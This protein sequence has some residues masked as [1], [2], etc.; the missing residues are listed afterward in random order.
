MNKAERRERILQ[1][2]RAGEAVSVSALSE[3]MGVSEVTIRK[4]LQQMEREGC[5]R[6]SY[7]KIALPE[8]GGE[9]GAAP[10]PERRDEDAGKRRIGALAA[11]FVRDEDLIFIGPGQTCA[12]LARSLRD[13]K[14][15]S[16]ITMNVSAAIELS[17]A[18]EFKLLLAPG[19]FTRRGGAYYVT[20]PVTAQYVEG[21]FVDKLFITADGV[22]IARGFSVLDEITAQIYRALIKPGTRIYVCVSGD[23]LS[24]NARAALGALDFADAVIT[25]ARPGEEFMRKFAENHIEVYYPTDD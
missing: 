12:A 3:Q 4:D 17:G 9:S 10:E 19:D 20:G 8:V 25:D 13:R 16:V 24:R 5:V 6:R 11:E 1:M 23:K 7:G 14:R 21:L 15:L 2:L 18:P 22:D